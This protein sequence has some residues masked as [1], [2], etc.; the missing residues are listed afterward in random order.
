MRMRAALDSFWQEPRAPGARGPGRGDWLL[1]GAVIVAAITEGV[2]DEDLTW[3][4]FSVAITVLLACLLPWRRV[5]PLPVVSLAFGA[6]ALAHTAGILAGS[7]WSGL[8]TNIVIVVLPYALLRWGSGREAVLGLGV[9]AVSLTTAMWG[10]GHGWGEALGA[11]LFLLFP[12]ALGAEAL[13]VT[14]A[15]LLGEADLDTGLQRRLVAQPQVE[16]PALADAHLAAHVV[17]GMGLDLYETS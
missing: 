11:S 15:V 6:T 1:A 13:A 9:M 17:L 16:L 2:V 12:A 7:R 5:A 4:A 10:G 8:D 14:D 3:R